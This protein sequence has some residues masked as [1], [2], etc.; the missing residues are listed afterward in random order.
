MDITAVPLVQP[1]GTVYLPLSR[2]RRHAFHQKSPPLLL[3]YAHPIIGHLERCPCELLTRFEVQLCPATPHL[4]IVSGR[5]PL[6]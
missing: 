1:V 6:S 5:L 4:V 2:V 3:G